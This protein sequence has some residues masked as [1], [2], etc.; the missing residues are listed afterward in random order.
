V[1]SELLK[2][3]VIKMQCNCKVKTWTYK[4]GFD[5]PYTKCEKRAGGIL[6]S[7]A[8][9]QVLLVQSRGKFWGFPKGSVEGRETPLECARRE[10][11]E[12]TSIDIDISDRD[13]YTVHNLT[14]Y[15]IKFFDKK[16]RICIEKIADVEFNDSTGVAWVDFSCL[17][18]FTLN[19]SAKSIMKRLRRDNLLL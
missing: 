4:G 18:K 14:H 10:I 12:E 1:S 8:R 3:G 17:D 9:K 16:P 15:Y 13:L 7:R 11:L 5:G 2:F 6:V 19:S